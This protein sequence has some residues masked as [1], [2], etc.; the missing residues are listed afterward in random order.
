MLESAREA[1]YAE[2]VARIAHAKLEPRSQ[3][4][5]KDALEAI[6][7]TNHVLAGVISSGLAAERVDGSTDYRERRE[8]TKLA[9]EAKGELKTG[10]QVAVQINFPEG[11]SELLQVD[12]VEY[13]EGE[14]WEA[15]PQ[16][17]T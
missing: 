6:G 5:I 1:G 17:Q 9:L 3:A 10:T 7:V 12:A 16:A 14:K 2:S 4:N 11:L 8:Y 13:I 15:S